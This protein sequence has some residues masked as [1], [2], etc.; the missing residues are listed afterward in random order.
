[1]G[2]GSWVPSLAPQDK[3]NQNPTF[4]RDRKY[5]EGTQCSLPMAGAVE[6][7]CWD[8]KGANGGWHLSGLKQNEEQGV[9]AV[10]WRNRVHAGR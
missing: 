9:S 1:M 8:G 10:F 4:R 2:T 5:T 3:T 6:K 7:E